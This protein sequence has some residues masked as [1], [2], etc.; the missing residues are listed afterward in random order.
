MIAALQGDLSLRG[1][2]AWETP[3]FNS[4]LT[5]G[6]GVAGPV[7]PIAPPHLPHEK[8]VAPSLSP[9]TSVD[10]P[11][12]ID[13]ERSAPASLHIITKIITIDP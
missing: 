8:S 10:S 11:Q 1:R 13:L 3:G 6:T 4:A 2:G 7:G 9:D 12:A 5:P